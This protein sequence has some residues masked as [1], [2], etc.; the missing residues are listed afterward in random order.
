MA[1]EVLRQEAGGIDGKAEI[2]AGIK[3]KSVGFCDKIKAKRSFAGFRPC[4]GD[5]RL[6]FL[7]AQKEPKMRAC[8]EPF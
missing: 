4:A 6:F 7:L 3:V 8:G 1:C 5:E 2:L